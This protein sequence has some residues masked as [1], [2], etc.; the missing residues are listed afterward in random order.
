[1][2]APEEDLADLLKAA[3]VPEHAKIIAQSE[4][5]DQHT[6]AIRQMQA[7]LT[8]VESPYVGTYLTA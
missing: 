7:I 5:I 8:Q 2:P 1:M 4:E 3:S 6:Q